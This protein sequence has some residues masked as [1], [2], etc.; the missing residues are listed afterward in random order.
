MPVLMNIISFIEIDIYMYICDWKLRNVKKIRN[1]Y[2]RKIHKLTKIFTDFS[3]KLVM[4]QKKT[5]DTVN[6]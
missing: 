5:V 2:G 1:R 6:G 4:P 3:A